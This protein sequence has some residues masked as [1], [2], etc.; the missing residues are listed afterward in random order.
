MPLH[1]KGEMVG[2][3]K[4]ALAQSAL[5]RPVARVFAVVAGQFVGAGEFPSAA[6]PRALVRF[7]ARVRPV[8]SL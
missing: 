6:F 4:G 1:V 3:G 7:L 5:E 8:V 2:A